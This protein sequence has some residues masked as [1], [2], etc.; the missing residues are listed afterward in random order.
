MIATKR[1]VEGGVETLR[2]LL[3]AVVTADLRLNTPRFVTLPN[4]LKA[5]RKQIEGTTPGELGVDVTPQ[6]TTLR[7]EP[8][9]KRKGGTIVGSVAELVQKLRDEA[10]VL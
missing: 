1:E 10:K 9:A 8:P 6:L 5:K 7:Y 3:P 2:L 4:T